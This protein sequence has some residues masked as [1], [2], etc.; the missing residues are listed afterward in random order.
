MS[1][2]IQTHFFHSSNFSLSTKQKEDKIKSF[3]SSHF[4]HPPTFPLLHPNR[5]LRPTFISYWYKV[6][7][8]KNNNKEKERETTNT[9]CRKKLCRKRIKHF[10]KG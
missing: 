2:F 3:L 6:S 9:R 7:P 10:F 8:K 5:P 1:K 4:S